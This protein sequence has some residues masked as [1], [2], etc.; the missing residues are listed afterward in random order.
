MR[1]SQEQASSIKEVIVSYLGKSSKVWLFGSRV[2]DTR[3]LGGDIDL[4]VESKKT[5]NL[6]DKLSI[7][8]KIQ[9]T[10]GLRKIGLLINGSESKHKPM[11]TTAKIEG[12]L[13]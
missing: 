6:K 4:Y 8:T 2:D 10:I 5:C 13:L 7:V 11:Y 12:V 3:L 1:L 9:R